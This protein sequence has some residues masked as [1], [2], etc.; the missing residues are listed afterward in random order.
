[1]RFTPC[2]VLLALTLLAGCQTPTLVVR[3]DA[4]RYTVTVA[5]I[6]TTERGRELLEQNPQE[7]LVQL[8]K[9]RDTAV[10]EFPPVYLLPDETQ[11]VDQQVQVN[12]PAPMTP[13]GKLQGVEHDAVG[14]RVRATLELIPQIGPQVRIDVEDARH[15][16]WQT[17]ALA[18]GEQRIP[19]ID[20][21]ALTATLRPGL[22]TWDMVGAITNRDTDR[23]AVFLVRIDPPGRTPALT[24]PTAEVEAF[25]AEPHSSEEAIGK[26]TLD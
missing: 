12:Y 1:M 10:K 23:V 14:E 19:R 5:R 11:E 8:L 22:A 15:T 20:R 17:F 24:E 13:D 16:G 9:R 2:F 7:G 18:Q 3:P 4:F 21:D 6:T 25:A 26:A